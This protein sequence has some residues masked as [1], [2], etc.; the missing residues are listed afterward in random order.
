MK[1][2]PDQQSDKLSLE[3][4]ED[5]FAARLARILVDHILDRRRNNEREISDDELYF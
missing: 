4:M 3:Q 5:L 1:K 2:Q